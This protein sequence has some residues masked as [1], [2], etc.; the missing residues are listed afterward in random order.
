[1]K[2]K[3]IDVKKL[4]GNDVATTETTNNDELIALAV[5]K[6]DEL[7]DQLLKAKQELH[8]LTGTTTKES[9]GPGVI[10]TILSLVTNSGDKGISKQA[11]L[12]KLVEMFPDHEKEGLSKTINVQLPNRMSKE[13]NVKIEKTKEGNFLLSK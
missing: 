5:K 6:V 10:L 1:M 9:K 4:Q 8:K 12:D 7:K 13:R 2:T 11:I 3:T